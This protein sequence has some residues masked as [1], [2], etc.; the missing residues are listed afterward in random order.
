MAFEIN[1]IAEMARD[2]SGNRLQTIK[3]KDMIVQTAL[4][5]TTT[6]QAAA[7]TTHRMVEIYSD[8]A[9]YISFDGT[10]ATTSDYFMAEGERLTFDVEPGTQ[11]K[12]RSVT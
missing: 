10:D 9:C 3:T 8:V 1:E 7:A 2:G 12:A 5:L 4:T 11:I 6:S